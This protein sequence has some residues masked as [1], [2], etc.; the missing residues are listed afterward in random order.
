MGPDVHLF[1][2]LHRLGVVLATAIFAVALAVTVGTGSAKA[3]PT[4]AVLGA[5]APALPSCPDSCQAIG[6][7]TG[8]QLSIGK[9]KSPFVVPYAGSIVAWSIKLSTPSLKQIEFFDDFFGGSPSA[10]LSVLKPVMKQIKLGKPIYRLKSQTPVEEL[11][12]FLGT[13]T[14]FALQ[15]PLRVKQNQVVALTVPTWAPA[16]SVNLG[17]DTAWMA[18]RKRDKCN[19]T[20]DIKAGSAQ[21]ALGKDRSYSCVYKTARLL[22]SATVVKDP[23]A[24]TGTTEKPKKKKEKP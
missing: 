21:E 18:S 22:Y 24:P 9:T 14:T 4:V 17:G 6:K 19:K 23:N 5:A 16:F 1:A 11:S 7:T 10:R 15:Q 3:A 8:V 13:T 2:R 12:T 20:E